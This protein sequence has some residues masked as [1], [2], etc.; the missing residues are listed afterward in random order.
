MARQCSH[1]PQGSAVGPP[2]PSGPTQLKQRARMRGR[3]LADAAHARQHEAV[4]QAP[5]CD[6]VGEG[7]HQG[8]LTDQSGEIA[9]PILASQDPIAFG[10][11]WLLADS[12]GSE[13]L[14]SVLHLVPKARAAVR[15]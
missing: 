6:R 15:M 14:L 10:G 4:R 1:W 5:L 11:P 9:R 13:G 12:R 2:L 3:G 7:A 8:F